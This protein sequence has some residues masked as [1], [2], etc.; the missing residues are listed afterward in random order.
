MVS[1]GGYSPWLSQK[2]RWSDLR[3]LQQGKMELKESFFFFSAVFPLSSDGVLS[4]SCHSSFYFWGSWNSGFCHTCFLLI[5]Q[6]CSGFMRHFLLLLQ[7]NFHFPGHLSCLYYRL[8][9]LCRFYCL[10]MSLPHLCSCTTNL[11]AP[12]Q[13]VY[14]YTY[15][16]LAALQ[17]CCF[18]WFCY[19]YC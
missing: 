5:L 19:S 17:K 12:L 18:A 2:S 6:D 11:Y 10:Q 1:T 14:T 4:P 16:C 3:A 8:C 15:I 13:Y 7:D 9:L